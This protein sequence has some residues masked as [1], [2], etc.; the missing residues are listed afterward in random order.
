MQPR[1][2]PQDERCHVGGD[3]TPASPH[4]PSEGEGH[5]APAAG[6]SSVLDLPVYQRVQRVVVHGKGQGADVGLKPMVVLEP[7]AFGA[8]SSSASPPSRCPSSSAPRSS[9]ALVK[10]LVRE[11]ARVTLWLG[12]PLVTAFPSLAFPQASAPRQSQPILCAP[13]GQLVVIKASRKDVEGGDDPYTEIRALRRLST[14]TRTRTSGAPA[15]GS[16]WQQQ[17]QAAQ[18]GGACTY[19]SGPSSPSMPSGHVV[20]LLDAFEDEA[21]VYSVLPYLPGQDLCAMLMTRQEG[22]PE[23][24]AR[25]VMQQ[26]VAALLELQ[27]HGL[28]HG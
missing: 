24:H 14:G 27:Q 21:H 16:Q 2:M 15:A 8:P 9:Y 12:C 28:A 5:C 7:T 23:Q 19:E 26:L 11:K 10:V 4:Q 13:P 20:Q 22:L 18:A 3:L 17:P 1:E 25:A 6:P